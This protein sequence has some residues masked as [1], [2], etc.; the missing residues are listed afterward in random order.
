MS[1]NADHGWSEW[2]RL[3]GRAQGAPGVVVVDGTTDVYARGMDNALLQKWWDG[4]SWDPSDDE[5]HRHDDGFELRSSPAALAKRADHR[6]IVARGK[7][8]WVH[9]KQYRRHGWELWIQLLNISKGRPGAV[10]AGNVIDLYIRGVHPGF[11]DTLNQSWEDGQDWSDWFLHDDGFRMTSSPT[12]VSSGKN[13]RDVYAAG[14]DGAV[15]HKWWDGSDWS[16]WASI[17]GETED[18]PGVVIADQATDVYVRGLDGA[19]WQ[20]WW[21]GSSWNPSEYGWHRHDDG[22]VFHS[23][24]VVVSSGPAHRD[25]YVRGPDG[26]IWHKWYQG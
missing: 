25:V 19:L 10:L 14:P 26:A 5:W 15:W 11:E 2:T 12:V 16:A 24:P 9:L 22:F 21:D 13:H 23:G 20:K 7:D 18:E 6:A 17:G 8:G 4:S 1:W 3:G